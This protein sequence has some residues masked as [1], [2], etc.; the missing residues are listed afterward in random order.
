MSLSFQTIRLKKNQLS[1]PLQIHQI[2]QIY[3]LG[4]NLIGM[5]KIGK[6]QLESIFA[7]GEGAGGCY[8]PMHICRGKVVGEF[9]HGNI[10]LKRIHS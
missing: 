6:S 10:G 9:L 7:S 8:P 3:C 2:L 4:S 5:T 1:Q